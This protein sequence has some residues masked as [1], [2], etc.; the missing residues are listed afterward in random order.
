MN[1][2]NHARYLIELS[3]NEFTARDCKFTLYRNGEFA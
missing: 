1:L 3:I 2:W